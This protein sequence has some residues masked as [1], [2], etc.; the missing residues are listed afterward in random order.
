MNKAV[1]I[2]FCVILGVFVFV[3]VR[4]VFTEC[5]YCI[6]TDRDIYSRHAQDGELYDFLPLKRR[7]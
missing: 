1:C 7:L 5:I 2:H 6:A 3:H 4:E